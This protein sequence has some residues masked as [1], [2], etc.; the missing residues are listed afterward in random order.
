MKKKLKSLICCV[1]IVSAS[2]TTI[3]PST[4][5]RELDL[6]K[7]HSA[8]EYYEFFSSGLNSALTVVSACS[9]DPKI[10]GGVLVAQMAIE[11]LNQEISKLDT[12]VQSK[13]TKEE[14]EEQLIVLNGAT[15]TANKVVEKAIN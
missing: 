11:V 10:K 6:Q 7:T 3:N 9:T 13:V 4:G 5:I 8:I 2:C 14:I 1:F 12:M 15:V